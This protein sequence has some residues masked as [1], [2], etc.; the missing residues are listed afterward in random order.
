MNQPPS[1]QPHWLPSEKLELLTE[2]VRQSRVPPEAMVQFI[3]A[4]RI[5]PDWG[6]ML[7]PQ[8]RSL[9]Q[10]NAMY[11][12]MMRSAP[13][14][15]GLM[16]STSVRDFGGPPPAGIKRPFIPD[17]PAYG[18]RMIQPRPEGAPL[19][20]P[21]ETS[22]PPKKKRGRPTKAEAE[23]RKQA[24]LA[25]GDPWPTPRRGSTI[26][27][28]PGPSSMSMGRPPS[29]GPLSGTLGRAPSV[30]TSS[31]TSAR[32]P[33]AGPAPS[34]SMPRLPSAGPSQASLIRP[35]P[36]PRP[37]SARPQSVAAAQAALGVAPSR[38]NIRTPPPHH[39]DQPDQPSSGSSSGR[40]RRG[41]PRRPEE[42]SHRAQESFTPARVPG[43]SR[44][45]DILSRD[46]PPD[47]RGQRP[48]TAPSQQPRPPDHPPR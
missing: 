19:T 23:E 42:E 41:R 8:R 21:N 28:L 7:L 35:L 4:H 48:R 36:M 32:P 25:R 2:I 6:N 29:S 34:A 38:A 5:V 17:L 9:N 18:G 13:A 47:P 37:P 44:Y 33:S 39:L 45:P 46:D 24:A 10:C 20:S 11:E 43:L 30:G 16:R 15:T 1:Q 12:E 31:A 26:G 14:S 27:P 3:Q 22:E 40:R